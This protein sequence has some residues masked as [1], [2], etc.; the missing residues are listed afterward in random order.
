M[1]KK[2]S[3]TLTLSRKGRGNRLFER[4]GSL[5]P[6]PFTGEGR[7]EGMRT[8]INAKRWLRG[9]CS[10]LRT[11]ISPRNRRAWS[12][13]S[14]KRLAGL[15]EYRR[16]KTVAAF[17]NFGSEIE[18]DD[19]IQRAWK[20]G[21]NVVIPMCKNGFDKPYFVLFR[22]GDQ[23]KKTAHGP[24]E[25]LERRG[26]YPLSSIDLVVVPGLAFDARLHRLGYGGGV[27]DRLL[28]K[29]RRAVHVGLFMESQELERLP[30]APHDRALHAVVTE[31]RVLR[32][33]RH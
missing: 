24:C 30:N 14:A 15:P 31:K 3:L 1:E 28:S 29:T 5:A 32:R 11:E 26:A 25:L 16:A 21:K 10:R 22:R 13:L 19:F 7:G 17:I 2:K 33:P 8:T 27:Y 20:D 4:S 6:S 23:L 18:T 12:A 9:V